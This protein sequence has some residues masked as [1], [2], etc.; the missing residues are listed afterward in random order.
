MNGAALIKPKAVILYKA[1]F[2]TART[3]KDTQV[4]DRLKALD[5]AYTRV[6]EAIKA[7]DRPSIQADA[8]IIFSNLVALG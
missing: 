3:P 7:D 1:A 2:I 8:A 6:K 4:E 5:G